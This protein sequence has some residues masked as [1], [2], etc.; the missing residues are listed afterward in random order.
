MKTKLVIGLAL[1][2]SVS[3]S[4]PLLYRSNAFDVFS[5]KVVQ[6]MFEATAVSSTKIVS[7]YLSPLRQST[8]PKTIRSEWNLEK[9]ISA[10]PQYHSGQV[11]VDA[12]YAKALE[13]ML[14]DV[15]SDGAF[16]AGAKW[17]G[18]WT[19]DISYSILLSL[20]II[21]P[22]AAKV[23]LKAKVKNDRIIQD[24]GTGG[25]WPISTDRMTWALA[26][27]EVY[28]V[29]GDEEWLRYSYKVIKNSVEDDQH[30]V[31]NSETGLIFG[32]SSFLDWR[33]QSYPRWMDPKDIYESQ[34]LGTNAVHCRTYQILAEMAACMRRTS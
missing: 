18:I 31:V 24:T 1:V 21:N 15:R 12:L 6:S 20:A 13:E 4:Q 28:L 2:Y 32:E 11:L 27:W 33:E 17:D 9:N 7:N 14:L 34:A 26:A 29:T 30:N 8:D 5:S 16:M 23:S 25:S 10:Y 22:D 3:S 19:R